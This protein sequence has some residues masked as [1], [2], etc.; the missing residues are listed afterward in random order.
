MLRQQQQAS[1]VADQHLPRLQPEPLHAPALQCAHRLDQLFEQ[2]HQ[3]EGVQRAAAGDPVRQAAPLPR[4]HGEQLEGMPARH[5]GG[6]HAGQAG[7]LAAA[8]RPF[9]LPEGL[10]GGRR[11]Q[12]QKRFA[13]IGMTG[14]KQPSGRAVGAAFEQGPVFQLVARP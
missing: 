4:R 8:Q 3:G 10:V 1:A 14:M 9:A 12:K 13:A 2:R 7:H 6:Q 5:A 11:R